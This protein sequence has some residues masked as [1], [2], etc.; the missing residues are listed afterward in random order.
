MAKA[1]EKVDFLEEIYC[2]EHA[3]DI[4]KFLISEY[5][6]EE[7]IKAADLYVYM[8]CGKAR[9]SVRNRFFQETIELGRDAGQMFSV[10]FYIL[11]MQRWRDSKQKYCFKS[12]LLHGLAETAW[13]NSIPIEVLRNLPIDTFLLDFSSNSELV[14][15][16][17][18][19]SCLVSVKHIQGYWLFV[20]QLYDE[21]SRCSSKWCA[22]PESSASLHLDNIIFRSFRSDAK[23]LFYQKALFIMQT[24]L[25]LCGKPDLKTS[26][27]ELIL[28]NKS[29]VGKRRHFLHKP[30]Q[31]MG[32]RKKDQRL[33][34]NQTETSCLNKNQPVLSRTGHRSFYL[35]KMSV[36][37]LPLLT[38]LVG[39][40][41]GFIRN[42]KWRWIQKHHGVQLFWDNR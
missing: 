19:N 14:S 22:I 15:I 41:C 36:A 30:N 35:E 6:Y 33:N 17:H 4:E 13:D 26:Q 21:K 29:A 18:F 23:E 37:E 27:K 31:F 24:V 12:D 10:A 32:L 3:D 34:P 38:Y 16:L 1:G 42:P 2:K 5:G 8:S 7:L 40:N 11:Q 25:Y 28:Y 20:T 9:D 39:E